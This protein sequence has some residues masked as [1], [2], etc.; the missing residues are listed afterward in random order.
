MPVLRKKKY[1]DR[2]LKVQKKKRGTKMILVCLVT[3]Q[4]GGNR[5]I[6]FPIN[7]KGIS[8]THTKRGDFGRELIIAKITQPQK[9]WPT[10]LCLPL[11]SSHSPTSIHS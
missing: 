11:I 7:S 3:K 6:S 2:G 8:H 1:L 9:T 10:H 5:Q 4:L